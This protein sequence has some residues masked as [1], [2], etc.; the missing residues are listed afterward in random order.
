M[1]PVAAK[2]KAIEADEVH[3]VARWKDDARDVAVR[4]GGRRAN[5]RRTG[6]GLA[7][8]AGVLGL[9]DGSVVDQRSGRIS[10]ATSL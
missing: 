2:A 8:Q 4:P 3:G 7:N 6:L 1:F 10:V 5:L 9:A